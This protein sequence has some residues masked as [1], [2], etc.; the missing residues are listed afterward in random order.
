M[1][2]TNKPIASLKVEE[3]TLDGIIENFGSA[4]KNDIIEQLLTEHF[5]GFVLIDLRTENIIYRISKFADVASKSLGKNEV[6]YS[7]Y[8]ENFLGH[9]ILDEAKKSVSKNVSLSNV[10]LNLTNKSTY[11]VDIFAVQ[12]QTGIPA[13]KRLSYSY[14]KKN[15]DLLILACEDVSVIVNGGIDH[16]T[17]LLDSTGFHSRVTEWIKTHPNEKF[18]ILRYNIDRFRDINGLFGYEAGNKLLRDIARYMTK[19]DNENTF[20]AHLSADYFVRFCS[21]DSPSPEYYSGIFHSSFKNYANKL[22]ITVHVGVYDLCEED[23]SPFNM[24]YKALLALQSLKGRVDKSIAYYKKGMAENEIERQELIGDVDKAIENGEFETWF[25]PQVDYSTGKIVGAEALVRWRHP[26]K[27]LLAPG[28]FL[29]ILETSGKIKDVDMSMIDR[30][31][32][33]IKIMKSKLPD[34]KLTVSGNLSRDYIYSPNII[35]NILMIVSKNK[36]SLRDV[37]FEITESAYMDNPN[38]L[39]SKVN[40]MHAAGLI[41]EMDDFGSAYSSLNNL[42]DI[43][44]DVL[45]LDMKFLSGSEQ[46]ERSK[47]IISSVI[48]M[49]KKLGTSVIA[50]GVE[51]KE[52]ADMLYGFG[53]NVMQ[54]YY[55]SKPVPEEEYEKILMNSILFDSADK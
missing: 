36:V 18:R 33:F 2:K 40:E 53:C 23:C 16:L 37:K 15:H 11:S 12:A 20:S 31:C 39:I 21:W 42:K 45:K 41:V 50:E 4:T 7:A 24:N 9:Y 28:V 29:P 52:Q 17:G 54:G 25:Q 47:I 51:T 26:K 6:P 13:N 43:N 19:N 5:D 44:V 46:N 32:R 38:L 1:K 49:A 27:G 34:C 10:K 55:F 8:I 3:E 30:V 14:Y 35:D 48:D 22:P